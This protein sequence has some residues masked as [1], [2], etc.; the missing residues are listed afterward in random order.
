[1]TRLTAPA[2]DGRFLRYIIF[3]DGRNFAQVMIAEG[4]GVEFTFRLPYRYL[5]RFK[6]AEREAREQQR[7]L[8]APDA[9]G[10][11]GSAEAMNRPHARGRAI[12]ALLA[13]APSGAPTLLWP[14][15]TRDR[16][17]PK[18]A[19]MVLPRPMALS[20]PALS[21]STPGCDALIAPQP[22]ATARFRMVLGQGAIV[23]L[24][25]ID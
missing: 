5:E 20:S 8:W 13:S 7:G 21:A 19:L 3:P 15:R 25:R 9:C 11:S 22:F 14:R 2:T 12:R 23:G 4:Y 17:Q 10:R 6:A 24:R 18:H 1:L 16:P